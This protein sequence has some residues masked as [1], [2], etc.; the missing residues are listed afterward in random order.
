MKK[1]QEKYEIPLKTQKFILQMCMA[2][3]DGQWFLKTKKNYGISQANELNQKVV[4]SIGKIEVRHILSALGIKKGEIKTVPEMFKIMNTI[5]DT[6]IPNVMKFKFIAH[7]KSEGIG[8]VDKCFIWKEV[9]KS[10]EPMD[11]ECA[12]NFRHRGWLDAMGIKGE[13]VAQKRL[14]DGDDCCKFKFVLEEN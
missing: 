10:N 8:H 9:Q 4:R 11:Y 6:I 2:Q 12:C 13:I 3:W 5:M 1:I 7:S 14:S